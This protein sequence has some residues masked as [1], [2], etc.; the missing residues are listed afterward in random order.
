M[1]RQALII[2]YSC[3]MGIRATVSLSAL[4]QVLLHEGFI[5]NYTFGNCFITPIKVIN[6]KAIDEV[7]ALLVSV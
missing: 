2:V 5:P 3:Q 4:R 7:S 6:L 1:M